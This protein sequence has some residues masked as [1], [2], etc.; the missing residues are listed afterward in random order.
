VGAASC[1]TSA[2]GLFDCD[3][4]EMPRF[5]DEWVIDRVLFDYVAGGSCACCGFQHFLPNGTAD[6][7]G[8]VT[9]LE[10]DQAAA[11]VAALEHHPWP[12]ELRDQVW[13]DR[14]K[15][16]QKLK[17]EMPRYAAFW[18]EDGDA[19]V[20]WCQANGRIVSQCLQVPR[21]E[22][23]DIVR[24]QYGVHSA[25]GVVLCAV[26]EQVANFRLTAYSM[27]A[28]GNDETDPELQFEKALQFGRLVGGFTLNMWDSETESIKQDVWQVWV[29]RMKSLCG[30]KL[31]GR[32]PSTSN[33]ADG[34]ADDSVVV[35]SK[36]AG[37]SFQ[38]DRRILRLVIAR[39]WSVSLMKRFQ[40]DSVRRNA[41]D[42]SNG[43]HV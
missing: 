42:E 40:D 4:P 27:D 23:L 11:E 41:T 43:E 13:A 16:R 31:L 14:V 25:Y 28:R 29:E 19:F 18:G 1:Q 15:V 17:K 9:D 6:L 20:E 2:C 38:S 35:T 32:G 39:Y 26:L 34:D 37:P 24:D 12:P 10:T 36:K 7:I 5:S 22:I 21:S 3:F 30:P 8:A 33:E